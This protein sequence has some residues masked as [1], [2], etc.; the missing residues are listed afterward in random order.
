MLPR[1]SAKESCSMLVQTECLPLISE[2]GI[3]Q[4]SLCGIS[5]KRNN[6]N[7]PLSKA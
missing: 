5:T 4:T 3:H 1:Y 6:Y 2:N 7:R